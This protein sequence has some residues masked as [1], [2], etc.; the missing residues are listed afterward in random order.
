M[1]IFDFFW[2]NRFMVSRMLDLVALLYL[3]LDQVYNPSDIGAN[4][5]PVR[6]VETT[7]RRQSEI[8]DICWGILSARVDY[9]F[10][11]QYL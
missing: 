7:M 5:S 9:Y 3:R 4:V 6:A 8:R 10:Y 11:L 1:Y 2:F